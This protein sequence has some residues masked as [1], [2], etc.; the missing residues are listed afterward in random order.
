MDCRQRQ[1]IKLTHKQLAN[2]IEKNQECL[3]EL[4]KL[5]RIPY[6]ST[7]LI[8]RQMASADVGQA[9]SGIAILLTV[10]V[11]SSFT[12]TI[13]ANQIEKILKSYFPHSWIFPFSTQINLISFCCAQVSIDSARN[14]K[15][16]RFSYAMILCAVTAETAKTR[17]HR[18]T[19]TTSALRVPSSPTSRRFYTLL[20]VCFTFIQNTVA[21][22]PQTANNEKFKTVPAAVLQQAA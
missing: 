15:N 22:P 5:W 12:T 17:A 2:Q 3:I 16:D 1:L 11:S 7:T 21:H 18:H 20:R 6:A 13:T 4:I 8:G 9:F 14:A 19:M 10:N